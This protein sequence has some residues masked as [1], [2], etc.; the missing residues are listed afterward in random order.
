MHAKVRRGWGAGGNKPAGPALKP[1]MIPRIAV[2]GHKNSG[3]TTLVER[4]ITAFT[5][6]G[7]AVAAIKHTSDE[8]GFDKPQ[9]DSDRLM[10]AGDAG[11]RPRRARRP[12]HV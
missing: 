8:R 11:A 3:K 1:V 10:R 5:R 12:R 2:V 4:L 7:L 6:D 9:T